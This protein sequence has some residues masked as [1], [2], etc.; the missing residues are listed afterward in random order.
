MRASLLKSAK[1]NINCIKPCI[2][3]Y[4]SYHK[5]PKAHLDYLLLGFSFPY[6]SVQQLSRIPF[7]PFLHFLKLFCP[8]EYICHKQKYLLFRAQ[9]CLCPFHFFFCHNLSQ[10][11]KIIFCLCNS[12]WVTASFPILFEPVGWEMV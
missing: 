12:R 2:P 3:V 5:K 4:I 9:H 8:L 6:G 11:L 7:L 10:I 1:Y